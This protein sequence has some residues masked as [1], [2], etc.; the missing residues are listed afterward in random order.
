M[1][2]SSTTN[3]LEGDSACGEIIEDLSAGSRVLQ[4]H[5]SADPMT[6][7]D[8]AGG[9]VELVL[10]ITGAAIQRIP[11]LSIT[12][13]KSS[14]PSVKMCLMHTPVSRDSPRMPKPSSRGCIHL[15]WYTEAPMYATRQHGRSR[16]HCADCFTIRA[17]MLA[18]SSRSTCNG[19]SRSS[20]VEDI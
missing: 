15:G 13:T 7:H 17:S 12:R 4:T 19:A 5:T 18:Y 11:Q 10:R 2:F 6:K 8:C 1:G 16:S 20:R 14:G 9:S 3:A